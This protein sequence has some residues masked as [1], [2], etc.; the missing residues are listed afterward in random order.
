MLKNHFQMAA[1]SKGEQ[2][3][4][5]PHVDKTFDGKMD[6]ILRSQEF[7]SVFD[8]LDSIMIIPKLS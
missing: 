2:V 3:T 8:D 1:Y 7:R 6:I 5:M 4:V